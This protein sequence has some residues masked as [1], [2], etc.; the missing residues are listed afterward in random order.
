MLSF[1]KLSN[2]MTAHLAR[3]IIGQLEKFTLSSLYI[4]Q[5]QHAMENT[6]KSKQPV[7][8]IYRYADYTI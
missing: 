2:K 8:Y 4:T 3:K 6:G 7:F 5:I 1:Q